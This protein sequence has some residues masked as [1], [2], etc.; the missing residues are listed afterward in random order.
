MCW[1]FPRFSFLD[2]LGECEVIYVT[3]PE[4]DSRTI[5]TDSPNGNVPF[6][7]EYM[8]NSMRKDSPE[9][10]RIREA[11]KKAGIFVVLGY[12]ERAG[13]SLYIAQ[14]SHWTDEFSTVYSLKIVLHRRDRHH[15][16]TQAQDQAY[17]C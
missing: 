9:M 2:T 17:W 14:V 6:I 11:V 7:H 4:K 15:C 10:D 8:G 16:P 5:W 1:A 12:S 3:H 13:G